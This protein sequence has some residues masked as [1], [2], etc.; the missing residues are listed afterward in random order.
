[1]VRIRSATPGDAAALSRIAHA[2]KA[3][4]GYSAAQLEQWHDDLTLTTASIRRAP[5]LVA[6]I[7]GAA[8]GVLQIDD[9]ATPWSL[10]HL[11]VSPR[12]MRR[13]VGRALLAR[14]AALAAAA[15][16]RVLAIDADPNAE[17]F[18]LAAGARRVGAIAAPIAGD[19][20]RVRPQ[21][22]L[23]CGA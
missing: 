23:A 16:Q 22:E 13:G 15:G 12:H 5:T 3:H 9:D 6:E 17:P 10:A 8:A 18:Y 11:W 4:W 14:A 20:D 21:L 2:A 1:V 7:D 19:P